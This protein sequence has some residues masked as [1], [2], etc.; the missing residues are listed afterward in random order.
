MNCLSSISLPSPPNISL[1]LTS[2]ESPEPTVPGLY[3]LYVVCTRTSSANEQPGGFLHNGH[4]TVR[5][6]YSLGLNSPR[7]EYIHCPSQ[8]KKLWRNT[9]RMLL[10]RGSFDYPP[11]P[12]RPVS[13]SPEKKDGGL[14]PCIDYTTLNSHTIQYPHP[15]SLIPANLKKL[16]GKRLQPHL[17]SIIT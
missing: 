17:N 3:V 7:V 1:F 13:S 10:S 8:T 9:L 11:C 15:F 4:G 2:I 16:R 5:S 14:R 6:T 12:Q